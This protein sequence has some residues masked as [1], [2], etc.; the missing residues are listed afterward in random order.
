MHT[1]LSAGGSAFALLAGLALA[2]SPA[3]AAHAQTDALAGDYLGTLGPLHLKLHLAVAAGGALSGLLDSPDQGAVGI[4]VDDLHLEGRTLTFAVPAVS[5]RWRGTVSADGRTLDG[6]WTQGSAMP[7]SFHRDTFVA[8]AKPS[9]VDG[10]WLGML[11]PHRADP[12]RIQ[13]TI[14]SDRD[15]RELCTLDSPDQSAWGI[16]CANVRWSGRDLSFEVPAVRGAWS[17]KLSGDGQQ[18][19]GIWRQG[20]A[21]PLN[22]ARQSQALRPPPRP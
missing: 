19:S 4:P 5:G 20:G 9:P 10:A 11:Q 14:K 17:G 2:G 21:L 15:G 18:L 1:R 16:D 12:L 6:S 22:L 13:L 7:L 8:A 3:R